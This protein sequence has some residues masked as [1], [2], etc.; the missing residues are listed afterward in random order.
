MKGAPESSRE[1]P[2]NNLTRAQVDQFFET[3]VLIVPDVFDPEDLDPLIR[4]IDSQVRDAARECHFSGQ[5]K[6]DYAEESFQ[7]Q[8]ARIYEESSEAGKS[9]IARIE[10]RGGGGQH[11]VEMYRM[12]THPKLLAYL[13]DLIGGEI[14]GSSVFRLR[15]KLP[16]NNRGIVPWHQD[17]GYLKPKCDREM[18]ITCWIPLVDATVENGCMQIL[19]NCHKSGIIEHHKGGNAG[20]LV[21]YE[22]DLPQERKQDIITAEVPKGGVVFMTN[23]TPHC[24]TPNYSQGVRWSVDL[25]Y[26]SAEVPNNVDFVP[27]PGPEYDQSVNVACYPPEADFVVMSRKDPRRET[28]Y[29]AFRQRRMAFDQSEGIRIGAYPV[30]VWTQAEQEKIHL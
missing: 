19:P 3:G 30:R 25:R 26:Q 10:G 9:V 21:I 13:E 14:V 1:L 18:I 6:S 8:L 17:S 23:L 7:T 27:D 28:S 11:G 29:E 2:L 4:E 24:S 5:L 12:I 20:F 22:E 15:P 16:N